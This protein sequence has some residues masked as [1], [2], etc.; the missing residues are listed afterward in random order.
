[1]LASPDWHEGVVGIVASRLVERCGRAVVLIAV[2]GDEAKG[3]GRSI[4]AYDLHAG[5]TACSEH[6]QRFGGHRV[7]AGLSMS[8]GDIEAFGEALA[9]H[10]A[11]R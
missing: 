7:A 6:L 10:A 8:A 5:M 4:P 3:S 11:R 2:N 1:M 9:A